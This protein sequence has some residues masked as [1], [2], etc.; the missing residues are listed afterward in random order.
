M[1][2]ILLVVKYMLFKS[3]LFVLYKFW[4]FNVVGIEMLGE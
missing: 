4:R 3:L 2:L 1:E